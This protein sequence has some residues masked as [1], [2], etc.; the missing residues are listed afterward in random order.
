MKLSVPQH[1]V[2]FT[3]VLRTGPF[4]NTKAPYA[5]YSALVLDSR[6]RY[7]AQGHKQGL[8]V[9][10]MMLL[11]E[12]NRGKLTSFG[13]CVADKTMPMLESFAHDNACLAAIQDHRV[14]VV[15][16]HI[17]MYYMLFFPAVLPSCHIPGV[18]SDDKALELL[19]RATSASLRDPFIVRRSFVP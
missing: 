8:I 14:F 12:S 13:L 16:L 2:Y 19:G 3:M 15:F 10:S 17:P 9:W 4:F 11:P 1:T 7:L 18:Q 5:N 6:D